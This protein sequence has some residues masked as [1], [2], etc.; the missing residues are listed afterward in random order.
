MLP[1]LVTRLGRSARLEVRVSVTGVRGACCGLA[2]LAMLTGTVQGGQRAVD[3][4]PP[5]PSQTVGVLAFENLGGAQADRWIGSGIAETLASDLQS[6]HG[7]EV[8]SSEVFSRA[9]T[10]GTAIGVDSSGEGAALEICRELGAAWLI[11]GGYQRVGDQ[12]RI[13]ARLL[14]V[15]TGAVVHAVEVDGTVGELF[16][17]QDRVVESLGTQ[18]G[19]ISEPA[20]RVA[21]AN[22]DR[23]GQPEPPPAPRVRPP[24]TAPAAAESGPPLSATPAPA[25]A[26]RS[27]APTLVID[28]VLPPVAPEVISRDALGHATIRA[29]ALMTPL[30]LDGRL[31]E[32]VYTSVPSM[33]DFIQQE[34]QEGSVATEKTDLWVFFDDTRVYV[35]FRCWESDAAQMV[36][37]E[38]R[39]DNAGVFRNDNVAFVLDTFYDRRNSVEFLVNAIGGRMDGQITNERSYNGDWNPIWDLEVGRFDGGWTVEVAIPFKSLRYR[40]GPDQVWGFNARRVNVWKNEHSYLMPVP[41]ALGGGGIFLVSRAATLIGLEVPPRS[42]TLDIKPYAIT[43]LASDGT[44]TPQVVN[45]L[46]GDVGLDVKYGVTQNLVADL[47]V[48]TDF[49]QVEADEQQVNLTRFSLFFPE[50]REFFLENQGIFVFGGARNAGFGGGGTDVPVLFYSREIGLDRGREVPMDAGGRLTGR[51]GRFSVGFMN[52]QTGDVPDIGALGTNFTVARVR[53]DILRR[54]NVGALFTGRSVSKSGA[55]SSETYGVDG[56]FSFYDNLNLNTYWSKTNTPGLHGDDVSYRAQLD[57]N[58]DRYG[59]QAEQLVVGGEFKPEVGFLRRDDF[60]RRFGLF[61]FSPRPERIAAVRKFTFEGQVAYVLDRAGMLETREN[62]GQF[63]IEF[64]NS[65]LFTVTHTRSY[66]FLEQPFQIAPGVTLPVGGY[67]FRDTQASFTLGQQRML[68]GMVSLQH[69]SFFSGDKTTVGFSR[70]R[71]ELT[72]QLSMEPSVSY[73]RVDLPEGRFTTSLVS[74]RTTYTVT[75]LMFVS[76]LLQYNSSSRSLSTNVRLRWEYQ[77]GSELFVVYN[78]QRDT[79]APTRFPELE[80]RALIVKIN[81]LFRF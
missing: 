11:A 20:R 23:A 68:S 46:G 27:E 79:L 59:V 35:S 4:V 16:G 36:V 55:G 15:E 76:A 71:L 31:D 33:S 53:R 2:A 19:T 26:G 70:G 54:S 62:R 14:A 64:Q 80:N 1:Y 9:R 73:N 5:T 81:R 78:E 3:T 6:V 67:T 38:M 44:V 69:G 29:V 43:D 52:I 66:E 57:Y 22:S 8:L 18:L 25:R 21:G 12:L 51:V 10:D 60:D 32:A 49:A 30:E 77:P 48:N 58:G 72:P 40:P 13:T 28:G 7:V 37:N 17:L 41:S 61:R 65:D 24:A 50:K 75:P 42:R 56:L 74:T 39:R 47:T 34:P 45:D 63:G